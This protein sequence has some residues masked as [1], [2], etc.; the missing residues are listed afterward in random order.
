MKQNTVYTAYIDKLGIHCSTPLGEKM[1]PITKTEN[2]QEWLDSLPDGVPCDHVGCLS[3]VSHPCE[4]CGRTAGR[5]TP[6]AADAMNCAA[7][8]TRIVRNF[9]N[10]P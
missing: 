7:P 6:R 10:A 8:P 4:V 2:R 5:R 3:H 1:D 9:K